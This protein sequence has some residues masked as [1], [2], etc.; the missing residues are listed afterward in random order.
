[1]R[2]I[3]GIG[4]G[5]FL[6]G[7]IFTAMALAQVPETVPQPPVILLAPNATLAPLASLRPLPR[8]TIILLAPNATLAPLASLRPRSR[9]VAGAEPVI[10]P[11][12]VSTLINEDITRQQ[13]V[14]TSISNFAVARSILPRF[15]PQNL[16][17]A[18]IDPKTYKAGKPV[19]Y[20]KK[21]S[22]CGIKGIRGYAVAP[23]RGKI[24]GCVIKN[25]VKVSEVDGITLTREV[26]I[27][28]EAAESLYGWVRKSAK[29]VVGRQGGGLAKIQMIAGYSCRNRNSAKSGKLSEHA[30]GKAV[31]IAGFILKDGTI[32]SVKRDWHS[33][34][35][36]RTLKKLHKTACGPFG[37]VLGPNANR[38]HQDHF[39]FD[40][41]RY[42]SGAYC[43]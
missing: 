39:H 25:P 8:P 15:R 9:P 11:L 13:Q 26:L 43:R 34:A 1:M 31:D 12:Q 40:V 4:I 2:C 29:P 33:A 22:V 6:A 19:R 30:K 14:F 27:G 18:R 7:Q 36:G 5:A 28:C 42:R 10:V 24:A 17:I 16:R 41:A 35:K 37:T 38:F 3:S 20:R 32:L 21:G 23:V